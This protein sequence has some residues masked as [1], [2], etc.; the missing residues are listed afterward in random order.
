MKHTDK[1]EFLKLTERSKT[2]ENSLLALSVDSGE[3]EEYYKTLKEYNQVQEQ[4]TEYIF[5]AG[6][7]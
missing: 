1:A 7:C 6:L 2:L 3:S 4:I 5:K